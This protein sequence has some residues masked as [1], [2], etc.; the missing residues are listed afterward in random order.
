MCRGK[1]G[2]RS[3][4]SGSSGCM[5]QVCMC[6]QS[7]AKVCVC[8]YGLSVCRGQVV[9]WSSRWVVKVGGRSKWVGPKCVC[10]Q[11]VWPKCVYVYVA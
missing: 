2:G 8:V 4:G 5:P 11:S 7:V 10:G 6:G 1:V 9:G 3:S